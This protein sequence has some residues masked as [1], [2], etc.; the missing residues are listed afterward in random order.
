[1]LMPEFTAN[2]WLLDE[3]A[4]NEPTGRK[5]PPARRKAKAKTKT[6]LRKKHPRRADRFARR[7]QERTAQDHPKSPKNKS[8]SEFDNR[9]FHT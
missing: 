7:A 9:R 1:M 3:A 4:C 6:Q 8:K 5:E 2:I